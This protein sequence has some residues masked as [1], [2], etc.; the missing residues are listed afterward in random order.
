M[1]MYACTHKHM[2]MQRGSKLKMYIINI[3]R[4]STVV[5]RKSLESHT[6]KDR[7][8]SIGSQGFYLHRSNRL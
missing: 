3:F 1:Y 4:K 7:A 5:N 6:S 8:C 2:L